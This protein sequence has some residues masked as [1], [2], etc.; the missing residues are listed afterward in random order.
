MSEFEPRLASVNPTDPI[1]AE[2]VRNGLVAIA[3]EM[4]ITEVRAAY[5]S[6]VRDMLDFSTAVCDGRGRVLAQGLS[7]ALQLGAIP[8]FMQHVRRHFQAPQRGDVYLCNDPW[9]GG[10]HLPDFMFAQPVFVEDLDEPIAYSV[11]VSHMIDVGGR[12][13]GGVS[14]S[15]AS[16]WDEGLTVPMVKIC[17][18]GVLDKSLLALIAANTRDS[19][20]VL[21]DI[22]AVLAGLA[23]G[24]RQIAE[25]AAKLGGEHLRAQMEEFLAHTER[26]TRS[27]LA[28]IPDG[29][30]SASDFLDDDGTG[31][32]PVEFA[33]RVSKHGGEIEFDFTGTGPQVGSG[34]NCTVSDVM[35]VVAFATRACIDED[36]VVNDGFTRCIKWT[37]P[38]GTIASA[39]RPAAVGA[40][41]ASIYRLTDVAL[42][43][44]SEIAPK[45]VPAN[46]G[47]PGI[48]YVDGTSAD[49]AHWIFLDY[50]QGGWGACLGLDGLA[51]A[52]HPISNAANIPA[53]VIEQEYPLRIVRYELLPDSAGAGQQIG[54][55]AVLREYEFLAP[56]TLNL[57]TN[58]RL[59]PPQGAAGGGP[60]R[61]S[62][63]LLRR[64]SG[65]WEE[66]PSAGTVTVAHG[67]RYRVELASGGGYGPAR[68]R[69]SAAV[70]R[71]VEDGRFS[72]DSAAR[73]FGAYA[74]H[75]GRE[76]GR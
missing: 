10:V 68:E 67:D 75:I 25:L 24:A 3:E 8:R 41:A 56:A 35:S 58:R 76:A 66:L 42:M 59:Y 62:R 37:I 50:V 52:S 33:C 26:A 70:A 23:T 45:R 17:D 65:E 20:M 44:L 73:L 69:S 32:D 21:G 36:L 31:S 12:F 13:P 16:I 14:A 64:G 55:Q 60:G 43:A 30:G 40:R 61:P 46:D 5:S 72:P 11:I 48:T 22:R 15:A 27:A 38:P 51:A 19:A 74:A 28:S 57:R 7:L 63:C 53:E 49:G 4:A 54:A 71:D 6:V 1:T 9:Q 39:Q 18:A 2:I 29:T 34:I 47:G